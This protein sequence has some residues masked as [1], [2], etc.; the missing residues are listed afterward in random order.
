MRACGRGGRRMEESSTAG[1]CQK[2]I[3]PTSR[4]R[5]EIWFAC[6]TPPAEAG[7][8]PQ[9]KPLNK[10][11]RKAGMSAALGRMPARPSSLKLAK[12]LWAEPNPSGLRKSHHG[13]PAAAALPPPLGPPPRPSFHP[14]PTVAGLKICF[15]HPATAVA[16]AKNRRFGLRPRHRPQT[17]VVLPRGHRTGVKKP[18]FRPV[19]AKFR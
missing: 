17:T 15:L 13:Q 11:S 19:S 4:C 9:A 10:E 2:T 8:R 14:L 1:A 6:N 16:T 3:R 18:R 5:R 12:V 7:G